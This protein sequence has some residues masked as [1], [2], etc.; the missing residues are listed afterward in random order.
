[1]TTVKN[2]MQKRKINNCNLQ[3]N[4][5]QRIFKK[6]RSNRLNENKPTK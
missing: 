1:M 5:I 6:S 2:A 3:I 4:D